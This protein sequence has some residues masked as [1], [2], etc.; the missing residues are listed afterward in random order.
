MLNE[1]GVLENEL[2]SELTEAF[3]FLTTLKLRTNLEKLDS[4]K[5]IDNYISPKDLNSMDKDL[6][7]ESFKI[8]NKIKKKLETRYRLNYT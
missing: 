7:K 2:A 1:E 6:L 8:V 5:E 4:G 3:N